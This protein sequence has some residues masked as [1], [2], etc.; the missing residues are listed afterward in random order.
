MLTKRMALRLS[1]KRPMTQ[2]RTSQGKCH[3]PILILMR[4][5]LS[6]SQNGKI[7]PHRTQKVE[8]VKRAPSPLISDT[9]PMSLSLP[10]DTNN[11]DPESGPPADHDP[12]MQRTLNI[13]STATA[14]S[15]SCFEYLLQTTIASLQMLLRPC[16]KPNRESPTFPMVLKP[17]SICISIWPKKRT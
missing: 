4:H 3:P 13:N 15:P 10:P 14:S 16:R 9:I 1:R 12:G 2:R 11:P 7:F 17:F 8:P 6:Q 5:G